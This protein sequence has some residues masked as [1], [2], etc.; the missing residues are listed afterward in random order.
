MERAALV[1]EDVFKAFEAEP[2]SRAELRAR[3]EEVVNAP[4]GEYERLRA[5]FE[6]HFPGKYDRE[7]AL[8]LRREE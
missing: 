6:Q 3:F 8:K 4:D 5:L 1:L 2:P 7:W